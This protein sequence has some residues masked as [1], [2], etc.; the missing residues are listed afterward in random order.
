[1]DVPARRRRCTGKPAAERLASGAALE[2]AIAAVGYRAMSS[3]SLE[4]SGDLSDAAVERVLANRFCAQLMEPALREIGIYRQGDRLWLLAAAP[5]A[6][7]ELIDPR[8][9][10]EQVNALVNQAR[11]APR[12]CGGR[13]FQPAPPL[14]A[15][16]QLREAALAHSRDMAAHSYLEHVGRDGS[17]PGERVA[18]AG[19]RWR[20]V[21][22]NIA[23]GPTSARE[24]AD[25]WLAS[26][27]HCANIMDPDF[28]DTAVAYVVDS[29]SRKGVYWT[30]DFA[31]PQK[32]SSRRGI[33]PRS[34][35]FAPASSGV[36]RSALETRVASK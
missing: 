22:E 21:G 4:I 28:I 32:R 5:F 2:P 27:E 26:P 12:R 25:G 6:V 7:P 16:P 20:S 35:H 30:E 9:V 33:S 29:R 18:R 14:R 8:R 15:S 17:T 11:A 34:E 1:M 36:L 24:A 19:Y 13:L 23:A 3:V 10:A 31:A